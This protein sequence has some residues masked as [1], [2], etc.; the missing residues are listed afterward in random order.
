MNE[1]LATTHTEG[2]SW[3]IVGRFPTF[4]LADSKR[5]ELVADSDLQVKIHYQGTVNNR[6]YA[7][8]IRFNPAL[9][10]AEA[11]RLRKEVKKKRKAKL[12]K[13]RRKK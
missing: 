13:K 5:K 8:K 1:N 7:V 10:E 12:N 4:K 2:P 6:F 3:N 9:A 11:E